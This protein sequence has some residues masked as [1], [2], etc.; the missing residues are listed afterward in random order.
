M[1]GDGSGEYNRLNP[2]RSSSFSD[3]RNLVGPED[4]HSDCRFRIARPEENESGHGEA[5]LGMMETF[6][7]YFQTPQDTLSNEHVKQEPCDSPPEDTSKAARLLKGEDNRLNPPGSSSF[8]DGRNLVGPEDSHSDCR[9]RIAR[10][11]ENKSGHDFIVEVK[12]ESEFIDDSSSLVKGEDLG[13]MDTLQSYFQTSHDALS[14][15]RVKQEP[16]GSFPGESDKAAQPL[17]EKQMK[18]V[19]W[20]NCSQMFDQEDINPHITQTISEETDKFSHVSNNCTCKHCTEP[21]NNF[22]GRLSSSINI[23]NFHERL[24]KCSVC[25]KTFPVISALQIHG[26]IHSGE[27]PFKCSLC[28]KAFAHSSVL[29]VHKRTH[30]GERPYKCSVCDKAFAHLSTLY[31]HQRT[32]TGEK[33][34]K[35]SVCHKAFIQS[36][37]LYCHQSTHTREM[38]Y[39]CSVCHKAFS[40]SSHLH[41]HQTMHTVEKPHKCSVCHEAFG[42]LIDLHDH[43][44]MHTEE[45][46][47]KCS[48]CQ[49][50]FTCWK[51]LREHQRIHTEENNSETEEKPY[52]C[53]V[54][55]NSFT[56]LPSL[57]RH[58]K[59]HSGEKPYRC[60]V[61]SKSFTALSFLKVH[62]RI[63]R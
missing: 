13:T 56:A 51:I 6:Q 19:S 30:T 62:Q 54:C 20:S 24:H 26:R 11:E 35:C 33:P 22:Q 2:P 49:K 50:S 28:N 7:S 23:D 43:E 17:E 12:V 25:N 16:L 18:L 55:N 47:V 53:S 60:S 15:V 48:V 29:Y 14:N 59:M 44:R 38:P 41:F 4:S 61:C 5:H 1:N 39:K 58:Q 45:K 32:H 46:T 37:Q 31:N 9:F 57:K 52:R 42:Q 10:P 21:L 3:G 40:E 27:K 63:H 36:A 8:S 34:Y